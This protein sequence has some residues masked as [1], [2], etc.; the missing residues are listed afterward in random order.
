MQIPVILQVNLW[1]QDR[2]RCD[3]YLQVTRLD[4]RDAH[5]IT[6]LHSNPADL[7]IKILIAANCHCGGS[8]LIRSP[9]QLGSFVRHAGRDILIV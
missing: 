5:T 1:H 3:T 7:M 6:E 9:R 4:Q 2:F 8:A